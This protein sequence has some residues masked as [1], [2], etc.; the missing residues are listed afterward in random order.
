MTQILLVLAL[1]LGVCFG[2][3]FTRVSLETDV[4]DY[5]ELLLGRRREASYFTLG[6]L[7][8][9]L[10]EIPSDCVPFMLLAFFGYTR[11]LQ[12]D[13]SCADDVVAFAGNAS[14]D[15]FCRLT[16]SAETPGSNMCSTKNTCN[17]IFNNGGDIVCGTAISRCVPVQNNEVVL[18]LMCGFAAVSSTALAL[19]LCALAQYPKVA[20]SQEAH[21]RLVCAIADRKN[22]LTVVDPWNPGYVL[23]AAAPDGPFTGALSYLWPH[24]L[25]RL[26]DSFTSPTQQLLQR[27]V[28]TKLTMTVSLV[29]SGI[30]IFIYDFPSLVDDLGA[31]WS[32]LGI[33]VL[34]FG[35]VGTWFNASRLQVLRGLHTSTLARAD[36]VSHINRLAPFLKIPY[37]DSEE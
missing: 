5:D 24:E 34:S 18:T 8:P 30:A 25:F 13:V 35:V 36:V 22:G 19:S 6:D 2:S 31:S 15:A 11:S 37:D 1:L 21:E 17:D 7:I 9:K 29:F 27:H 16:F 3:A 23:K 12:T 32:P 10:V 28:I 33:M 14:A 20:R 4:I 26:R